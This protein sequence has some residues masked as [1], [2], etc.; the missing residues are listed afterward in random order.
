MLGLCTIQRDRA[1]W[2]EEWLAFH[3]VVGFRK[4]YFYAHN[5]SDDTVLKLQRLASVLD[6]T[7]F[8]IK[9]EMDFVQLKSY[10]HAY[11]N[12]GDQ[13]DWMAF[14]DGDEF[15]FPVKAMTLQDVLAD[16]NDREMSAL[17]AYWVCYGSG[18]HIQEPEGLIIDNFQE[19]HDLNFI[20]NRHIKS[21]VKGRQKMLANANS[22]LFVT[23]SGTF[24]ELMRPI[25]HG[26]MKELTPSYQKLRINHYICQSYEYYMN[27]K[28]QAGMADAGA[29]ARRADEWWPLHDINE[30]H[31]DLI[32]RFRDQVIHKIAELTEVTSCN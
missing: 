26:F 2:L 3:Y 10:Q 4:F 21:I 17:A 11:D 5:C 31:D 28:R 32:I 18:G 20:R 30:V 14:I 23:Q 16:Y 24:D 12:F 1:P 29:T 15:L 6:L 19:R 13:V 7:C 27:V 25:T 9:E 22:H 8:E